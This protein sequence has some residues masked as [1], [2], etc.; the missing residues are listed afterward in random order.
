MIPMIA[1]GFLA[2]ESIAITAFEARDIRSLR[3]SSQV[4]AYFVFGLYLFCVIGEL[5]NVGWTN[6]ALPEIYG[7]THL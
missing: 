5:L 6:K 3:R 2:I 7:G 1:Y 4:I